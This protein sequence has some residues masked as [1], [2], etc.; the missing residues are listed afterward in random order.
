MKNIIRFLGFTALIAVITVGAFAQQYNPES[1]FK[2][3]KSADGK[4]ITITEYVGK[5]T[6]VN[7]PPKIQN[8]PVTNI[9]T[10]FQNQG[11]I[12]SITIPE[13][14]TTLVGGAFNGCSS[15]KSITIPASVTSIQSGS[16][17]FIALNSV[18]FQGS[19]LLGLDNAFIGPNEGLPAAY[20]AGKAGTY[21][22]SGSTWT[23]QTAASAQTSQYNP[24]SDFQAS[25]SGNAVTIKNYVGKATVVNIPPTIQGSPVTSIEGF[26]NPNNPANE[27]ITSITIPENVITIGQLSFSGLESLA[28]LTIPA[29][30][31]S[32]GANAFQYCTGL[33]SVTFGGSKT[34][35]ASNSG[36][37]PSSLRTAYASGGAGTYTKSGSTWT[38][39]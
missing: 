27:K 23:K 15:L 19:T 30:V 6:V 12:T 16:F 4:S 2:V 24:E 31:T 14:V 38:K 39:K 5:A 1:D 34:T 17:G 32:I 18:T 9:G 25:K 35:I 29:S 26:T 11:M 8:L 3:T 28:S 20:Y 10:A 33:T 37:L 7:I 36:T 21:I 22:K 13:G